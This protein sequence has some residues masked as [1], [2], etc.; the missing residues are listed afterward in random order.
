MGL[1]WIWWTLDWG[2]TGRLLGE[3]MDAINRRTVLVKTKEGWI[4]TIG[5]SCEN[6]KEFLKEAEKSGLNVVQRNHV[7]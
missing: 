6:V 1:A 4:Q 2:R 5:T 7:D 3:G